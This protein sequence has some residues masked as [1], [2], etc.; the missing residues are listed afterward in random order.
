MLD[1]KDKYLTKKEAA[2]IF[3]V[4][5]RTIDRWR[6]NGKIHIQRTPGGQVRIPASEIERLLNTP[7][8]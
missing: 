4:D 1:M 2:E 6:R 8:A 7:E 5:P 3:K